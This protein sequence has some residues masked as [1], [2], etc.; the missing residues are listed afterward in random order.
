MTRSRR[1]VSRQPRTGDTGDGFGDG[2]FI[3]VPNRKSRTTGASHHCREVS[4]MSLV[5]ARRAVVLVVA[6]IT[7]TALVATTIHFGLTP[8]AEGFG[9]GTATASGTQA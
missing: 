5:I 3:A 8:L 1:T 2:L 9:W 7:I 6:V 4:E